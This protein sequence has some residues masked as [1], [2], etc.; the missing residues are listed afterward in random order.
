MIN[1]YRN[2]VF[3]VVYA[4]SQFLLL[5]RKLNWKGWE[6]CK[7]GIR[8]NETPEQAVKREIREETHLKLLEIKKFNIKGKFLYDKK[9]QKQKGYKGASY[10]LFSALVKKGKPKISKIEHDS[11]KWCAFRQALKL[12]TWPNQKKCL[13]IV[14]KSLH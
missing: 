9:A 13:K 5:H 11:Y 1:S 14:K 7:G 8:K 12:L 2:C 4:D 3:C 10:I 6:F